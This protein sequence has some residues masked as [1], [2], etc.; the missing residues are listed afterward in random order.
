MLWALPRIY[1]RWE[2]MISASYRV[3]S[4]VWLLALVLI[5]THWVRKLEALLRLRLYLSS[6]PQ[7]RMRDAWKSYVSPYRWPVYGASQ[8]I[9]KCR[10]T[11]GSQV[12]AIAVHLTWCAP[13]SSLDSACT[14][15][16]SIYRILR[17]AYGFHDAAPDSHG[18]TPMSRHW[19]SEYAAAYY[20]ASMTVTTIGYGD[21]VR[22][23]CVSYR[24]LQCLWPPSLHLAVFLLCLLLRSPC[25]FPKQRLSA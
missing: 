6:P 11:T 8:W 23:C 2:H 4:I 10:T 17:A 9:L 21:I 1:A 12:R 25:R 18:T 20:W 19:M 3:L 22:S 24:W 5:M 15:G 13:Y 7:T 16:M 14:L